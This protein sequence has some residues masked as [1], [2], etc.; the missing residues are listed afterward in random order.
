MNVLIVDDEKIIVDGIRLLVERSGYSFENVFT[1]C[2]VTQALDIVKEKSIDILF[3]DIKMPVMNGFEF[4]T[5]I[6][7]YC[8]PEIILISGYAEFEYAHQALNAGVMGY[9]LKPIDEEQFFKILKKAVNKLVTRAEAEPAR[10][11][12]QRHVAQLLH[13]MFGGGDMSARDREYL[14]REITAGEN[15][16]YVLI[17]VN[18]SVPDKFDADIQNV[19]NEIQPTLERCFEAQPCRGKFWFF[20]NANP[21]NL[22][23]L[24]TG[25]EDT[26]Q[27]ERVCA[28]FMRDFH[29]CIP[30]DIYISMSDVRSRLSQELYRHA[31]EAYYERFLDR[32]KHIL[33]YRASNLQMASDIENKLKIIELNVTNADMINLEKSLEEIFSVEYI[34]N[35][36]LTVRAVYFLVANAVILTFNR[37]K[38][39]IS[40]TVVEEILSESYL[41]QIKKSVSELAGRIY[42]VILD[43]LLEQNQSAGTQ[44]TIQKIVSYIDAN[45]DKSLSVKQVSEMFGLTPNYLSQIFKKEVG[46]NF[47]SYLNR[48][49]IEK[50]CRLLRESNIKIFEIGSMVGYNDSQYFY[51]VFKKYMNQT[52]IEYR[53]NKK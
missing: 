52:P 6:H 11:D 49:R 26:E 4:I 43:V 10:T 39:E 5:S 47:V 38:V 27:L 2:S 22:L 33:K 18:I 21:N 8:N 31:Q 30:M 9:I 45:F 28:G 16:R 46:K 15:A 12:S 19:L 48:L 7:K 40:N 51:R 50:A 32:D 34:K 36:G 25:A 44:M 37:I 53:M 35:S 1:A 42:N 20:R 41:R 13:I 23:C 24:C 29:P 17:M 14:E 3:S